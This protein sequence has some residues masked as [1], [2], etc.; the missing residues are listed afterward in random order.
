MRLEVH[1]RSLAA[2]AE[3]QLPSPHAL[4]CVAGRV[5][6][7]YPRHILASDIRSRRLLSRAASQGG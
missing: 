4:L 6:G 2:N 3:V 5:F 1:L 7:A